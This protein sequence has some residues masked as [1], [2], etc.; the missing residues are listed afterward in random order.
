MFSRPTVVFT[1][2]EINLSRAQIG[3]LTNDKF[4]LKEGAFH[5][6]FASPSGKVKYQAK[7]RPQGGLFQLE[8]EY[9]FNVTHTVTLGPGIFY[10]LNPNQ[11]NVVQSGNGLA[12]N[13]LYQD[14]NV[15]QWNVW[16]GGRIGAVFGEDSLENGPAAVNCTSDCQVQNRVLGSLLVTTMHDFIVPIGEDEFDEDNQME[17]LPELR[18]SLGVGA[19][20]GIITTL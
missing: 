5:L 3:T 1:S 4:R 15:A 11:D 8:M 20:V 19:V 7:D 13:R 10:F 9:T 17:G 18:N 16:S 6:G 12:A 2:K 14:G